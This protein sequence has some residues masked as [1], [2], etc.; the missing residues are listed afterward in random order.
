[1]KKNYAAKTVSGSVVESAHTVEVVC[2]A[3]GF[4]LDESELEA[5]KCSD[6]GADL[7]L[8]RSVS[9]QVTSAPVFGETSE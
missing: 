8:K 3:C 4:D 2:A 1:M 9:I 5:D 7:V 6:C